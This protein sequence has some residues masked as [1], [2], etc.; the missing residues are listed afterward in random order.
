MCNYPYKITT[1]QKR[2]PFKEWEMATGTRSE[3]KVTLLNISL[4]MFFI[5]LILAIT[6][7]LGTVMWGE[8]T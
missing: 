6:I 5:M 1:E 8:N 4:L 7:V 3:C 2:R